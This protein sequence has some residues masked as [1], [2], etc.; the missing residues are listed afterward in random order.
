MVRTTQEKSVRVSWIGKHG[1]EV[2]T[3]PWSDALK[4]VEQMQSKYSPIMIWI[5]AQ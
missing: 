5:P 1:L 3:L 4:L 2:Y